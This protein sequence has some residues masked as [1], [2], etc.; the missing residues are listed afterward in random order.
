MKEIISLFAAELNWTAPENMQLETCENGYEV[1]RKG[2]SI[3]LRYSNKVQLAKA[4]V[5]LKRH[6]DQDFTA[7][8][9]CRLDNM[10][11]MYDCSRNGVLKVETIKKLIRMNALMGYNMFLWYIE[12][13]YPIDSRPYFGY[14]RG[15]Y[16]KEELQEIDAYGRSLDVQV[17]PCIQTLAHLLPAKKWWDLGHMFDVNDILLC[18]NE[19]TYD[20]I[21][22]MF[23]TMRQ[24]FQ[25]KHINIGMDEA[26]MVGLGRYLKQHG[27]VD[28]FTIILKHLNRVCKIAEKYGFKPH[29]WSDMFF[30]EV[31]NGDYYGTNPV[32]QEVREQVPE[33]VGLAYWDYRSLDTKQYDRMLCEHN[34]FGRDVWMVNSSWKCIGM[35]PHNHYTMK[36][37]NALLPAMEKHN[38][39]NFYTSCWGDNGADCSVFS[40]LPA[41]CYIALRHY[42][43]D[44][45]K[46]YEDVFRAVTDMELDDYLL[47]DTPNMMGDSKL[48]I[49]C[50]S[51]YFLFS[52][53][54]SGFLD[55]RVHDDYAPSMPP[56]TKAL[57]DY[58]GGQFPQIFQTAAALSHVLELKIDLGIRTR[59]AYQSQ[60]RETM[61]ELAEQVYPEV[62]RRVEALQQAFTK[63]WLTECKGQGLE[64]MDIRFGGLIQRLKTCAQRLLTHLDAGVR[65]EELEDEILPFKWKNPDDEHL[66]FYNWHY[67]VTV[68]TM[69]HIL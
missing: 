15:R 38:I 55:A 64:I 46:T 54:F 50:P 10:G 33:N 34:K 3:T 21:D 44:D 39:K 28:C 12:D 25:T 16:S 30:R 49:E 36:T 20:W 32:P 47:I 59:K 19:E 5:E 24:C 37:T 6:G 40:V 52:D 17:V 7:K 14:L 43:I 57:R 22:G 66:A 67:Y 27:Y 1:S 45:R 48:C 69:V 68:N 29:M 53:P 13:V 23:A 8:G 65:I 61:R 42:G 26:D 9:A 35:V 58:H 4:L 18:D 51:K 62:I 63:Q 41:L 56:I 11:V 2:D 31:N 60:D